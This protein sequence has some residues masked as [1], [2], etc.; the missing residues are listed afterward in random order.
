MQAETG[1]YGPTGY[2]AAVNNGDVI[3]RFPA[4]SGASPVY[5]STVKVLDQEALNQREQA[6]TKV[7][8]GVQDMPVYTPEM[9]KSANAL[10]AAPATMMF[11][12]APA[13]IQL[14]AV[15][16]GVITAVGEWAGS[17]AG[18]LWRGAVAVA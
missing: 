6:E 17:I 8:A 11:N 7:R 3:I 13:G 10:L 1:Q 2:T 18:A 9:V 4:G 14:S 5:V 16:E 15:G 12:R